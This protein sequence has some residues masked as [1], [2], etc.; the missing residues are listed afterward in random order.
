[1]TTPRI[2][3][4]KLVLLGG[5]ILAESSYFNDNLS[6]Y[7]NNSKENEHYIENICKPKN[8]ES[9]AKKEILRKE[10]ESKKDFYLSTRELDKYISQAMK[11]THVNQEF[12]D[13]KLIR[14][15]ALRES[16]GRPY[17][18]S[19]VG[20]EG[21]MQLMPKTYVSITK[22]SVM[23][24]INDPE[25]NIEAG[26]KYLNYL[27]KYCKRNHPEWKNLDVNTKREIILASYNIG[28][29]YVK[30]KFDWDLNKIYKRY[31]GT[32]QY[33]SDILK[34]YEKSKTN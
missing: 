7:T 14:Y 1:M 31:P 25:T 21:L 3:L 8:L 5:L 15:I 29:G 28:H 19:V 18:K 13:K 11:K 12:N 9:V 23:K 27:S 33:V 16:S 2:N 32:K 17:A 24:D 30:N 26:M 34:N 6:N 10:F 22:D 4:K 20:A